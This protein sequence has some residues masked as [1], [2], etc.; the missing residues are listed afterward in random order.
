LAAAIWNGDSLGERRSPKGG[1]GGGGVERC[2][3]AAGMGRA[4]RG[5]NSAPRPRE[6][7]LAPQQGPDWE[8]ASSEAHLEAVRFEH[9]EDSLRRRQ[10]RRAGTGVQAPI[11]PRR[12]REVPVEEGSSG[13]GVSPN[14]E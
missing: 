6:D 5:V 13:R 10:S 1:A 11:D 12:T 4:T 3:R 9:R 7:E 8:P 2:Y 14:S